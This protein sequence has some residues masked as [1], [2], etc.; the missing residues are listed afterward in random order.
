MP[1][2]LLIKISNRFKFAANEFSL[3]LGRHVDFSV[4]NS[5]VKQEK[6]KTISGQHTNGT[7]PKPEATEATEAALQVGDTAIKSRL[8][9]GIHRR[10]KDWISLE[11]Q[12]KIK[13]AIKE[14][15]LYHLIMY[16]S[17]PGA[18]ALTRLQFP[19]MATTL[20][21]FAAATQHAK[22]TLEKCKEG[23]ISAEQQHEE[24]YEVFRSLFK[25]FNNVGIED[26]LSQLPR[27]NKSAEQ[28]PNESSERI[29]DMPTRHN[30]S[31]WSRMRRRV[32]KQAAR[33]KV[34]AVSQSPVTMTEAK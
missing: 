34:G 26:V 8:Y 17:E 25:E 16:A 12:E 13:L 4:N 19:R 27:S 10:R 33:R 14:R 11:D 22:D 21:R 29:E 31:T 30:T 18:N 20:R 6:V 2:K 24:V 23:K 7:E 28:K 32:G 15:S 3:R 1:K 9:T 5:Q